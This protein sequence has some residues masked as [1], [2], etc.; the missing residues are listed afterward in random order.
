MQRRYQQN[1]TRDKNFS[2]Y[3]RPNTKEWDDEKVQL[4]FS[5]IDAGDVLE[6]RVPQHPRADRLL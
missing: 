4:A 2:Y 6:T 3:F 5:N 1:S